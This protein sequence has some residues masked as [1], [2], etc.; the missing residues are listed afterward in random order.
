MTCWGNEDYGVGDAST[1]HAVLQND[2]RPSVRMVFA[3]FVRC[4]RNYDGSVFYEANISGRHAESGCTCVLECIAK[5]HLGSIVRLCCG[6]AA[7]LSGFGVG[8]LF[9]PRRYRERTYLREDR[10]DILVGLLVSVLL[11]SPSWFQRSRQNKKSLT[12]QCTPHV[13]EQLSSQLNVGEGYQC[14]PIPST[15]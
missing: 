9:V 10:E 1:Q 3:P 8:V 4:F 13:K 12:R 2:A 6:W 14:A 11:W 15:H 7:T 5:I